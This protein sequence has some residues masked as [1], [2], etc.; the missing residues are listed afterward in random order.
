MS[1][2]YCRRGNPLFHT[3]H[4]NHA[5]YTFINKSNQFCVCQNY[6][7]KTHE[8]I[9]FSINYCPYCGEKLYQGK[10]NILVPEKWYFP[11]ENN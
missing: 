8:M 5:I 4:G 2:C 9:N 10:E 3:L 1:C 11:K 7:I 6:G